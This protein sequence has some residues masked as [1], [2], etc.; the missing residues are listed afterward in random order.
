M[1]LSFK[2]YRFNVIY[3]MVILWYFKKGIDELKYMY[4]Y[5]LKF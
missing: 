5:I 3:L 4:M 1:Y 2:N